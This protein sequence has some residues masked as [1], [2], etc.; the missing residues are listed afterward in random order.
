MIVVED[1]GG[2]VVKTAP[3]TKTSSDTVKVSKLDPGTEYTFYVYIVYDGRIES[4]VV[5]VTAKTTGTANA[6]ETPLA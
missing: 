5:E 6:N 3:I 2:N 1:E 4:E